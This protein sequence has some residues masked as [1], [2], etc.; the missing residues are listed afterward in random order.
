MKNTSSKKSPQQNK[1]NQNKVPLD[2]KIDRRKEWR[3]ELPLSAVVEGKLPQ[4]KKFKEETTLQ[5]ISAHGAYFFLNSGIT[6]GSKLKLA[7]PVPEE[8]TENKKTTL[9]LNGSV[10][11]LEKVE[12]KEKKQGVALR[13]SKNYY[14]TTNK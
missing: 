4:G 6:V 2:V 9:H 14:F 11:R 5:D 12:K 10:I 13:F 7:I 1:S 8:L 3:L